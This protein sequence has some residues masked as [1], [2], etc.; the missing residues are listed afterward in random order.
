VHV[1]IYNNWTLNSS[2]AYGAAYSLA[3]SLAYCL[4][5]SLAYSSLHRNRRTAGSFPARGPIYIV[6]FFADFVKTI[7][8]PQ[9]AS[10]L[11][12]TRIPET[13]HNQKP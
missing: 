12:E 7:F 9:Q 8:C 5:Y 11:Y 3:Y 4:A 1:Y 2:V 10:K 6:V 13:R